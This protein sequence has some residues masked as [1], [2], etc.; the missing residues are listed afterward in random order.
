[1]AK[2]EEIAESSTHLLSLFMSGNPESIDLY[3]AY[4]DLRGLL[5]QLQTMPGKL[6]PLEL[7]DAPAPPT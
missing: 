6:P 4:T 5:R 1:M 2:L 7:P 3:A